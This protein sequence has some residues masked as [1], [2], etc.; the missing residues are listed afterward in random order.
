MVT[1]LKSSV[2]ILKLEEKEIEKISLQPK[3]MD[4]RYRIILGIVLVNLSIF[5]VL[6]GAAP[7]T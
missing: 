7:Q 4:R 3:K 1:L 5:L 6:W 2:R